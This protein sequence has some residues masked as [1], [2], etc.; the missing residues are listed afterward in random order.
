MLLRKDAHT[1]EQTHG[2]R[3]Q[4]LYPLRTTSV[5]RGDNDIFSESTYFMIV[6]KTSLR[7]ITQVHGLSKHRL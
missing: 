4:L 5:G 2:R 3:V 6:L 1:G 7:D